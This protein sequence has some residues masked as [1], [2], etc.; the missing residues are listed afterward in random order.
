MDLLKK[1]DAI[2]IHADNRITAADR[3]FFQHHQAVYQ[4][5]VESFYQIATVWA[6]FCARQEAAFSGQADVWREK[7][8][9]SLWWPEITAEKIMKHISTLHTEFVSIV[10]SYLNSTYHLTLDADRVKRA[11]LPKESSFSESSEP[12]DQSAPPPVI[13]RYEDAVALILS[14][15]NG[16]TFEEQ[17][18]YE[19]VEKCRYA[20]WKKGYHTANFEQKKST[21]K[22]FSDACDFGHYNGY[23]QWH[24]HSGMKDVL[25]GLAHYETGSF[26]QYPDG[27]DRLLSDEAYLW[28]D[29]WEFEDCEKLD[30]IRLFKNGRMDIRFTNEGGARQFVTDYL[31]IAGV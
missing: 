22:F 20:A 5:A 9:T 25:K 14:W 1:F 12:S 4:D 2:E 18:P 31:G 21:V 17:A 24:I 10:V 13:L 16:R 19:L 26:G 29:L 3:Q 7:Y 6:G 30:R 23:E 27:I 15:F 28:F 11:L 8:L